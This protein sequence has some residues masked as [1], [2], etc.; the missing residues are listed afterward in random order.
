MVTSEL[1]ERLIPTIGTEKGC[2]RYQQ[3]SRK[4]NKVLTSGT[5][6]ACR[7]AVAEA[8]QQQQRQ[9]SSSR[10]NSAA[11]ARAAVGSW[12]AEAVSDRAK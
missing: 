4:G 12:A 2:W 7:Q 9:L 10:E 1:C 8:T 6:K 5:V 3:Q 11:A